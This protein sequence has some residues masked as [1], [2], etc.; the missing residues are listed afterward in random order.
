MPNKKSINKPSKILLWI[1]GVPAIIILFLV[2]FSSVAPFLY[3]FLDSSNPWLLFAFF[4]GL[5][6]L[7]GIGFFLFALLRSKQNLLQPANNQA[8]KRRKVA[9]VVLS[10]LSLAIGWEYS[11]HWSGYD[12]CLCGK[13]RDSLKLY[14]EKQERAKRCV[15]KETANTKA[16]NDLS[17][18]IQQIGA[19]EECS[20]SVKCLCID[21]IPTIILFLPYICIAILVS[22]IVIGSR[23][24][25]SRK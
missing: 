24:L 17:S 23:L 1:L 15:G 18:I 4:G 10:V 22:E 9:L 5:P 19:N 13:R 16:T 12:S 25:S 11:M 8:E 21:N 7:V 20:T 3:D 2:A 6:F 14:Q